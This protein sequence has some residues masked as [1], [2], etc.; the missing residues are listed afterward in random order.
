LDKIPQIGIGYLIYRFVPLLFF[1]WSSFLKGEKILA[2]TLFTPPG[3][4]I[5][6]LT[7]T[8]KALFLVDARAPDG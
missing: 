4:F 8:G 1:S 2:I 7:L 3:F 6:S 5:G